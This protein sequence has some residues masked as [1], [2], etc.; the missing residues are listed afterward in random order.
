MKLLRFLP[1]LALCLVFINAASAK[2]P[3][4][5][6]SVTKTA[7][8]K[9]SAGAEIDLYTCVNANGMVMKITNY[10][11]IVTALEAPDRDGEMANVT[12]GFPSL[13]GY[14]VK[15]PY[16]GA[17]V[18]RFCNRIDNAKFT[19]DGKEYQL[20]ANNKPH[21]LHGGKVGY[22]KV[23]WS[24]K[25]F[26]K[27]DGVGVSLSYLSKDGEEGYPGNLKISAIYTLTNNNEMVV[28]LSAET[29]KATPVNL[30]NHCYWNLAGEGSG[31]IRNHELQIMA[32]KYLPVGPSLIPTGDLADVQGTPLDFR[33]PRK[34]GERL[35]EIKSDPVGYDHCYSLR[36]Q[37]GSMALAA[38]VKDPSSGRVLEIHTTQP[39][40]Q[41]Y[42]GNFLD[43]AEENGGY[44]QY[45]GFCLETQHY[46]DSP[47]QPKFPSTI[48]KPGEKYFQKTIH[49]FSAE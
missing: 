34:I 49:R 3:T 18:G 36:G 22:D 43:G 15:P 25:P 13:A 17:T 45:E 40:L 1:L 41:F 2:E 24:A 44:K 46:P 11:G 14:L 26:Q 7:Y 28:A 42:S 20:F 23:V 37:D 30:T 4:K 29:D 35:D 21:H 31:T 9:T 27:D 19:L 12:L 39:G 10:G 48:L 16:F 8:G 6:M 47:N 38:R 5:K 32:D 33:K